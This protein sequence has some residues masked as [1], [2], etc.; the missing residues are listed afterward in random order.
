MS[1]TQQQVLESFADMGVPSSKWE[2]FGHSNRPD[3]DDATHALCAAGLLV[4]LPYSETSDAHG[5]TRFQV[6]A[7]GWVALGRTPPVVKMHGVRVLSGKHKA[8]A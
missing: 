5:G 4:A 7:M 3:L 2:V 1:K 8:R 6:T